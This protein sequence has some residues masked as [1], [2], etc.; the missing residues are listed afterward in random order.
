L[1]T[2][3]RLGILNRGPEGESGQQ[4]SCGQ[5]TR[6]GVRH[7]LELS[8]ASKRLGESR[9]EGVDRQDRASQQQPFLPYTWINIYI[10]RGE[11]R[12]LFSPAE[13]W[14]LEY[15]SGRGNNPGRFSLVLAQPGKILSE[16][17]TKQAMG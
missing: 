13:A 11:N 7:E 1:A 2:R 4:V 15:V 9:I 3:A 17:V 12:G 5:I 16:S 6:S 8:G 10:W 14:W